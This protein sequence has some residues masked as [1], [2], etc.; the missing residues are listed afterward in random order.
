MTK[1]KRLKD[2]ILSK[3]KVQS[4]AYIRAGD[5]IFDKCTHTKAELS[6]IP[7]PPPGE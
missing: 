6:G 1:P 2:K 3:D 7:G 4:G 5:I